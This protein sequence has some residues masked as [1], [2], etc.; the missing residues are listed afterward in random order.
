MTKDKVSS[1]KFRIT[2][3][4]RTELVCILYEIFFS[5]MEDAMAELRKMKGQ[6]S[7][8]GLDAYGEALRSASLVVRQLEDALDFSYEISGNL[9]SLYSFV[10]C[11]IAKAG[12]RM[13]EEDLENCLKVMKPLYESFSEIAAKD[14][15]KPLMQNAQKVTAGFTYGRN[16]V[17]EAYGASD[18][19][20]FFA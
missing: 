6:R 17:T 7:M 9:F 18:N 13:E 8:E 10:E 11:S 16:D 19:R 5:Y 15:S 12:Y 1:F 14:D 20:G 2:E 3:S 4:N